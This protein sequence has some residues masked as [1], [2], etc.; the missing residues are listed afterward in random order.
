VLA[1]QTRV[2]DKLLSRLRPDVV[3]VYPG[4]NDFAPY[5]REDRTAPVNR[6][7]PLHGIELP[8]WLLTVD[9]LLRNTTRLRE[10]PGSDTK[11]R[12][13][14]SVP[15]DKYRGSLQALFEVARRHK[16]TLLMSTNARSFSRA[17]PPAVQERLAQSARYYVNCFDLEG[18]HRLYETHNQLIV[19][20]ARENGVAVLDLAS[21]VPAEERLFADAVHFTEEGERLVAGQIAERL[22]ADGIGGRSER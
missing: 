12:S 22:L 10:V 6:P 1:V 2:L 4:F 9:L 11:Y 16:I 7:Q 20:V 21:T 14:E 8:K 17:Q 5:C 3:V 15:L 13:I 18:M 19:E